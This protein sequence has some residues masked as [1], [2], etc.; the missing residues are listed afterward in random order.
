MHKLFPSFSVEICFHT[1]REEASVSVSSF[2][3]KDE[4]ISSSSNVITYV[5]N[6]QTLFS[7]LEDASFLYLESNIYSRTKRPRLWKKVFEKNEKYISVCCWNFL[8]Y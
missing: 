3:G 4:T 6:N 7:I 1:S 2:L 8:K 5:A